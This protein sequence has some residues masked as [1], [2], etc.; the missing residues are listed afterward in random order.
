MQLK[1]SEDFLVVEYLFPNTRPV[2]LTE[3]SIKS[4]KSTFL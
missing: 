2:P 1:D 4:T 3:Y